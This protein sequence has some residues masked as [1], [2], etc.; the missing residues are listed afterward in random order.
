MNL[1]KCLGCGF[2]ITQ[3]PGKP[4]MAMCSNCN[5][6]NLERGKMDKENARLRAEN[7]R[8][9]GALAEIHAFGPVIYRIDG[10]Q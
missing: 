8:L 7:K 3:T 5:L 4:E 9:R 10:G 1:I 6:G 2:Y